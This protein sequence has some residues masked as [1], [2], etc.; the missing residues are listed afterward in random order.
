[1]GFLVPSHALNPHDFISYPRCS[2]KCRSSVSALPRFSG[3]RRSFREVVGGFLALN[4]RSLSGIERVLSKDGVGK[5]CPQQFYRCTKKMEIM[6]SARHS[7]LKREPNTRRK[8]MT[9][10]WIINV[11]ASISVMS[12][13]WWSSVYGTHDGYNLYPYREVIRCKCKLSIENPESQTMDLLQTIKCIF[14]SRITLSQTT[15]V[16]C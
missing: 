2:L 6:L 16:W 8:C 1:M 12:N 10:S 4:T 15:S 9:D 14:N 7:P 5:W 3:F 11:T 13:W